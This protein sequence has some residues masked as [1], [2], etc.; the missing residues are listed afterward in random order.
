MKLNLSSLPLTKLQAI[1]T[2]LAPFEVRL[3][4]GIVRDLVHNK[5]TLNPLQKPDID[6]CT[7]AN[8]DEMIAACQAANLRFEPTGLDHGT[9]TIIIEGEGFETTSLRRDVATD[10]RRAT[11]AFTRDFSEDATR[12]DFTI[13]ALYASLDGTLYDFTGG[14]DDLKNGIVRFIGNPV[15]RIQEDHLRILRFY[16]FYARYGRT[17]PDAATLQALHDL[18]PSITTL[19]TERIHP[20]F[21][22][23]LATVN[24]VPALQLMAEHSPLL[25]L[26]GLGE[27]NLPALAHLQ[28]LFGEC[29]NVERLACLLW[30]TDLPA[31]VR[32]S[33]LNPTNAQL[34][35]LTEL[36]RYK[37]VPFAGNPVIW[38]YRVGYN[39][40]LSQLACRMAHNLVPLKAGKAAMA[41]IND[42]SPPEFPITGDDLI[43]EGISPG[44]TLGQKLK[45]LEDWWLDNNLPTRA[46]C[47]RHLREIL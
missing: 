25:N 5:A 4:G 17:A 1:A 10:G 27:A 16:R 33:R 18:A 28:T 37:A 34:S 45:Q 21:M 20:E 41:K 11:V 6:L 23:L 44:P 9:I 24:P 47:L 7:T 19:P 29:N 15:E 38:A 43:N 2:A 14:V 35:I 42:A 31:T 30:H 36:Q 13:N 12:R 22:K 32:H 3:V 26:L 39:H 40:A 46:A 8:P